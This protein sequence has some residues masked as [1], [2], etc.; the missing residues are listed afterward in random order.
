[1]GLSG[2]N[3]LGFTL[4][5][6]E[7]TTAAPRPQ[8][9]PKALQNA[10][11]P[12]RRRFDRRRRDFLRIDRSPRGAE[13]FGAKACSLEPLRPAIRLEAR[14]RHQAA[15][16]RASVGGVAPNARQ[17]ER[18]AFAG[19]KDQ[20]VAVGLERVGE[21]GLASRRNR[22]RAREDRDVEAKPGE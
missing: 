14:L 4:F 5:L 19:P 13:R 10:S 7:P 8:N 15:D 12:G 17:V 21:F 9:G 16:E 2:P 1:Q 6:T 3:R 11:M 22:P 20:A 18:A